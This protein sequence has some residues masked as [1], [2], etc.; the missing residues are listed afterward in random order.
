MKIK[1]DREKGEREGK[2]FRELNQN[3]KNTQVFMWP[4]DSE[5][6]RAEEEEKS[7]AL[8]TPHALLFL[9]YLCSSRLTAQASAS[10]WEI[11]VSGKKSTMRKKTLTKINCSQYRLEGNYI[12]YI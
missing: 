7:R 4:Q 5:R 11:M 12:K 10:V 2:D 8:F 6:E 9:S 1:R 3:P